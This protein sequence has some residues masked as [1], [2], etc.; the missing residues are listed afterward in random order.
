MGLLGREDR[1]EGDRLGEGEGKTWGH[2]PPTTGFDRQTQ[3]CISSFF[4]FTF[5][6]VLKRPSDKRET[7]N[8]TH[9][10]LTCALKLVVLEPPHSK[11]DTVE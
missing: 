1:G 4:F 9:L 5:T 8:M 3:K 7:F 10:A 2:S 11:R 6:L